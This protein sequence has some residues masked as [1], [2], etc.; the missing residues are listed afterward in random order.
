M[1]R[2]RTMVGHRRKHAWTRP[3]QRTR[4]RSRIYN[5]AVG[6]GCGHEQGHRDVY[7]HVHRHIG[8]KTRPRMRQRVGSLAPCSKQQTITAD[9]AAD[10]QRVIGDDIGRSTVPH[11]S[12]LSFGDQQIESI[13]SAMSWL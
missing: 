10:H 8:T 1:Q 2:T 6:H 3:L 7:G 9:E 13:S 12:A 4:T 11:W 5:R